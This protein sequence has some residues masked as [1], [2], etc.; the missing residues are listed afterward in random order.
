ME[1]WHEFPDLR[2]GWRGFGLALRSDWG[3][4][5]S[6]FGSVTAWL[7]SGGCVDAAEVGSEAAFGLVDRVK[8]NAFSI[9]GT[10]FCTFAGVCFT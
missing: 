8:R 4:A 3:C 10:V 6:G 9:E 2:Q 7:G 1:D 5:V